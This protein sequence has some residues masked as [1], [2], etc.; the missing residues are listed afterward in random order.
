[1]LTATPSPVLLMC[2]ADPHT[3]ITVEIVAAQW[4]TMYLCWELRI[5]GGFPVIRRQMKAKLQ[6][7]KPLIGKDG[8][9]VRRKVV[10]LL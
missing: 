4:S 5:A 7:D 10:V 1:M 6:I 8:Y 3:H 9:N 2:L